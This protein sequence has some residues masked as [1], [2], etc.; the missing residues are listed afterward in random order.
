MLKEERIIS[1]IEIEKYISEN[2]GKIKS[3]VTDLDIF[4]ECEAP[5]ILNLHD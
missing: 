1:A 2:I 3:T 5:T 4:Y